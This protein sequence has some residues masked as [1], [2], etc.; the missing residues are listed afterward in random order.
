MNGS[1]KWASLVRLCDRLERAIILSHIG[2]EAGP[3]DYSYIWRP[4]VEEHPQNQRRDRRDRLVSALRDEAEEYVRANADQLQALVAMLE[5]RPWR[6]FHRLALH[7]LRLFR[8]RVP[9]LVAER[10]TDRQRFE[11]PGLR[12]EYALLARD[13]FGRLSADEQAVILSWIEDGPR[14]RTR[15]APCA[16]DEQT[17][18][19]VQAWKLVRL[20]PIRDSLPPM[21][22]QRYQ[23]WATQLGE[24]EH[25]EFLVY[26]SPGPA[27][28]KPGS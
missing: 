15:P 6:I 26:H 21:W 4:A 11:A 1:T 14:E 7:V 25:P 23:Q 10:L 5:A 8:D 22:R 28:R 18:R 19:Q 2:G 16:V 17:E 27:R 3:D 12:H 20:A 13:H 9:A 24:P